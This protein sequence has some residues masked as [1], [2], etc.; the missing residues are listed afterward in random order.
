M[1][2]VPLFYVVLAPAWRLERAETA[3]AGLTV[4]P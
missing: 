1:L 3:P 4:P 2:F